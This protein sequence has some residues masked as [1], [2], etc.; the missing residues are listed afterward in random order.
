MEA[1]MDSCMHGFYMYQNVWTPVMG[2]TLV[3]QR[4]TI[5]TEDRYV[6]AVYCRVFNHLK[7]FW[8]R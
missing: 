3:C 1:S 4:E 6:V 2:E 7:K 8:H 5:N